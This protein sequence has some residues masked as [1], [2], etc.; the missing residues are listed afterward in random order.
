MAYFTG[1]YDHGATLQ[2]GISL[3]GW[4]LLLPLMEGTMHQSSLAV[5]AIYLEQ[6]FISIAGGCFGFQPS[7]VCT[8]L[9]APSRC[10]IPSVTDTNIDHL[11]LWDDTSWDYE[12][13]STQIWEQIWLEKTCT[14]WWFNF[15][16]PWWKGSQYSTCMTLWPRCRFPSAVAILSMMESTLWNWK[17]LCCFLHDIQQ[18]TAKYKMQCY[19][20]RS[21]KEICCS[22]TES[23]RLSATLQNI[24]GNWRRKGHGDKPSQDIKS[25]LIPSFP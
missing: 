16:L 12:N 15:D 25:V 21:K 10:Q 5:Y 19:D 20:V 9:R 4:N 13:I 1:V 11:H 2:E 17:S 22:W 14:K 18:D 24:P 7:T 23:C 6:G 3:E 8:D